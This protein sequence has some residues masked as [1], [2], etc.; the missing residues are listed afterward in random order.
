MPHKTD[1]FLFVVVS[2]NYGANWIRI[3]AIF[4]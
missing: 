4:W 1:I 3:R 2:S